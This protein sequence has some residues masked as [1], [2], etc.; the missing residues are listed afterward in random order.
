MESFNCLDPNQPIEGTIF[1]EAS[2][3]TG[4]TFAIEHIVC[5]LLLRGIPLEKI[6]ITTFT[7]KGVRDLKRRIFENI[8]KMAAQ[9][10]GEARLILENQRGQ[11]ENAEIHTIHSF[12]YRCLNEYALESGISFSGGDPES[13]EKRQE[14]F[15]AIFDT[16]R[17]TLDDT[18]F[19]PGQLLRLMSH[20]QR[21][22]IRLVEKIADFLES[23]PQLIPYQPYSVLRK[24]F[25][26]LIPSISKDDLYLLADAHKKCANRAGDLFAFVTEQIEGCDDFEKLISTTP[27]IFELFTPSN[28]KKGKEP[29]LQNQRAFEALQAL[30][31]EAQD[32]LITFMRLAQ[33]AKERVDLVA[34]KNPNYLLDAMETRLD[35]PPFVKL[36][37]SRYVAVIIDEF[38]DTDP[39]QWNIFSSLF[40]SY[41]D[42]FVVVGD[43]KQSI[44]A[45]RGANLST[46]L[47]AKASFKHHYRLN[48]N[49]RSAKPIIE[50]INRLFD[51][52]TTQGLF[53][54]EEDPLS[55]THEPILAAREEPGQVT[56]LISCESEENII[57]YIAHEICRLKVDENRSLDTMAILVKDRFQAQR[58]AEILSEKKIPLLSSATTN[59]IETQ[60]FR[61]IEL[62]F[63]LFENRR[64]TSLFNQFL[65]HPFVG[66]PF[67]R[68]TTDLTHP[69]FVEALTKFAQ[70]TTLPEL[71]RQTFEERPIID[72]IAQNQD[73]Y[74]DLLQ[75]IET[76]FTLNRSNPLSAIESLKSTL[77][78]IKR[79]SLCETEAVQLMTMHMSKGLE[80]D[81]VF[82]IGIISPTKFKQEFTHTKEK[83][84]RFSSDD[85]DSIKQIADLDR[86][87]MRLFYV[88]LTRAKTLLYLPFLLEQNKSAPKWGSASPADLFLA[89]LIADEPLSLSQ[90]YERMCDLPL[91]T[92]KKALNLPTILVDKQPLP[93]PLP[94]PLPS[95]SPLSLPQL[96][97]NESRPRIASFSSLATPSHTELTA[98]VNENTLPPGPI[99][100]N[101]FHLLFEKIIELGL[102]HPWNPSLIEPLIEKDLLHTPLCN[103]MSEVK[104][105]VQAAFHTPLLDFCLSDV[106]PKMMLQEVPFFFSAT[107][108]LDLKGFADLVFR[109]Q[110]KYYILD[111]K[112]NLLSD[113]TPATLEQAMQ[114]HDYT[115]QA[116]LYADALKRYTSV[117]HPDCHFEELFGGSIYFF[118]RGKEHG[119]IHLIEQRSYL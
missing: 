55:L 102:Y 118:L 62:A 36:V 89:R 54:F 33:K 99:T 109:H 16:L 3:G 30:V 22:T 75:S 12:C 79:R 60:A 5:R 112:L 100:G 9:L 110:G 117:I 43:P 66:R 32:P 41:V 83:T 119:V 67:E 61:F 20:F 106:D 59:L 113:Y 97:L 47:K 44:Y 63:R 2:A 26:E 46:Y 103:W 73:H 6:L 105:L 85:P 94:L 101:L 38:Q 56:A 95:S 13:E 23:N 17:T 35:H 77:S 65:C 34:M 78:P 53:T 96:I 84:K 48:T 28:L 74:G 11:M 76:I 42:P 52:S 50:T 114:A 15:K 31:L 107:D 37:R 111:W 58:V 24:Q 116:S 64:D 87:K 4:K 115:R 25:D 90:T 80:F 14:V 21:N 49:Y 8:K 69:D 81:V 40:L 7:K 1:L 72:I 51:E 98:E 104:E 39:K 86:E 82:P 91:E 68:L 57:H 92:L 19:S 18:E 27:S 70:V 93:L 88:A 71:L 108:E 29:P 45:F 10:D